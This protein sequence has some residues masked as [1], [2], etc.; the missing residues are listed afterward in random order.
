MLVA[1][2]DVDMH[3]KW[4]CA[5]VYGHFSLWAHSLR[6][7]LMVLFVLLLAYMSARSQAQIVESYHMESVHMVEILYV[8]ANNGFNLIMTTVGFLVM[9]SELPKRVLYQQYALIR[10]SRR[11]WLLSQVVFC[12]SASL[13]FILSLALFSALFSI[14]F[15]SPGTE[16]SDL[17][18][19][20]VSPDSIFEPQLVREYI[21]E[22]S[23]V[24]AFVLAMTILYLFWTTLALLILLIT[25]AGA[26]NFGV[27][28]CVSLVM[29]NITILFESLPEISF[30]LPTRFA[31]LA[32]VTGQ[33]WENRLQHAFKIIIGYI[34]VDALLVFM[35]VGLVKHMDLRFIGKE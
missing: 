30:L 23:P 10:L 14:P 18:R 17:E 11:K 24:S 12:L 7:I 1:K 29:A 3:K 20:A 9:M 35:M 22:I 21:R 8:Y 33:V 32:A 16:W 5:S 27:V 13:V 26:P 34:C 6:T 4:L 2:G 25:L 28:F 15:V 31:T 19:L